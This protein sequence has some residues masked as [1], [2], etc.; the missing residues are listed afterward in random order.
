MIREFLLKQLERPA[1]AV[2]SRFCVRRQRDDGTVQYRR[3]SQRFPGITFI[4][5]KLPPG[6]KV[7]THHHPEFELFLFGGAVQWEQGHHTC[8]RGPLSPALTRPNEEHALFP[9]KKD[10]PYRLIVLKFP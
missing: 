4:A 2:L 3:E 7:D 8:F 9:A 5:A 6:G 10:Q 1:T